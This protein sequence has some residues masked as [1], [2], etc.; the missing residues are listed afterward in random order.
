M[1]DGLAN[2]VSDGGGFLGSGGDV[3]AGDLWI[4]IGRPQFA[5]TL[6]LPQTG[7]SPQLLYR[8]GRRSLGYL[9]RWYH[10]VQ[11]RFL[12]PQFFFFFSFGLFGWSESGGN[13]N[14]VQLKLK[15][16][17]FIFIFKFIVGVSV[18]ITENYVG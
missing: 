18:V 7:S 3:L 9:H 13:E 6:H 2:S 17:F 8:L 14:Q 15:V 12:F 10:H 11:V 1:S 5:E 16:S 4:E